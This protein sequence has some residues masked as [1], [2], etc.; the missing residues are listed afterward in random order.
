MHLKMK[1]LLLQFYHGSYLMKLINSIVYLFLWATFVA[2]SHCDM[3]LC[4]SEHEK[5]VGNKCEGQG[6]IKTIRIL[7]RNKW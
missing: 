5:H 2:R 6:W 7:A 3:I 4:G 1:N